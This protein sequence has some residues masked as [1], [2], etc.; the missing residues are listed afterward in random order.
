MWIFLLIS[1]SACQHLFDEEDITQNPNAVNDVDMRTLLS[2]TLLGVAYLHQDTD[3]RIAA[4]W[5]RQINGLARAH[6]GYSQYIVSST[7]F[8]WNTLYPV[9]GQARLL[10]QKAE[11]AGELR[12]KGI[13]QVLEALVIAK[14][15]SLWGDVPYRQA[16]QPLEFPIPV[17]DDQAAVYE[18]LQTLLEDAVNNLSA[19]TGLG[20]GESDFFFGGDNTLWTE[21]AYTLRARLHLHQGAY[22]AAIEDATLGLSLASHD[23]LV[24]HGNSQGV[25]I[26]LNHDFFAVTRAGD[27][28]FDGAYFPELLS[29]RIGSSNTKT[30]ESALYNHFI[31]ESLTGPGSLDPNTEDGAFVA[32]AHHPVLTFYENQLI[33]AESYARTMRLEQALSTL[34]LVRESLQTGYINGQSFANGGPR[35]DAYSLADFSQGGLA[36]PQQYQQPQEAL[37]YEIVAQRYILLLMQYEAFNDYRRLASATPQVELDIPL[38]TG[39]Q[40]PQRF[41]YPQEQVNTNPN[42]PSPLPDQYT[43]LPVFE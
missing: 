31:K 43:E 27:T 12:I 14:A 8:S 29:S 11:E 42:T 1:A 13:A 4:L 15:T 7:N 16:F 35:Y 32:D 22:D 38:S 39:T 28:G 17:Y 6:Q 25:N 20:L 37:L 34:N 3:V 2:G 40:R 9:A 18:Q 19:D 36:N 30:D 23:I 26:N 33:L 24:P 5:A 10:Q 41:I 21:A